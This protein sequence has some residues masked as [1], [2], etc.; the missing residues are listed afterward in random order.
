MSAPPARLLVL[1]LVA[2]AGIASLPAAASAGEFKRDAASD[3]KVRGLTGPQEK[4]L[5]IIG[6]DVTK[7]QYLAKIIVRFKGNFEKQMR[8]RKLKQAGTLIRL[9]LEGTR[10]RTTIAS[11]G[12]G[13][14]MKTIGGLGKGGPFAAVREG[15]EVIFYVAGINAYKLQAVDARSFQ[16]AKRGKRKARSSA[17]EIAEELNGLLKRAESDVVHAAI[18]DTEL[19]T[20]ADCDRLDR[21]VGLLDNEIEDLSDQIVDEDDV[22][23]AELRQTVAELR[24]V[25]R[26]G[27]AFLAL[28]CKKTPG[29]GGG[30]GGGGNTGGGG[31]GTPNPPPSATSCGLAATAV[32]KPNLPGDPLDTN[33]H[34]QCNGAWDYFDIRITSAHFIHGWV[35]HSNVP[36]KVYDAMGT[37][38]VPPIAPNT[39]KKIRCFNKGDNLID[40]DLDINP[41]P[42]GGTGLEVTVFRNNA[43]LFAPVG[44]T[45]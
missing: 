13:K 45:R 38:L 14:R 27:K 18:T 21:L 9:K 29:N 7:T 4:A 20:G 12:S 19:K 16:G 2:C 15:R 37:E 31:G 8:S 42:S 3:V 6:V 32:N 36:C 28:A 1:L 23:D 17:S 24:R 26:R 39:I 10:K 33:V 11:V 25:A 5:D 44:L 34:G 41:N 35:A 22:E 30:N 40:I 43:A